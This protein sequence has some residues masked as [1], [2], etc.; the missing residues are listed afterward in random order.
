MKKYTLAIIALF[1]LSSPVF[2]ESIVEMCNA[3]AKDADIED[4]EDFNAYVN[5]CIEQMNTAMQDE[6]ENSSSENGVASVE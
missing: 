2:A 6:N 1:F 5:E 4:T 3:E